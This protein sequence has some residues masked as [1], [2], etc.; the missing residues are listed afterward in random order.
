[1]NLFDYLI[2]QSLKIN[3]NLN[4]FNLFLSFL[5]CAVLP[6]SLFILVCYSTHTLR[7]WLNLDYVVVAVLFCLPWLWVRILAT[8]LLL[9]TFLI[10][11]LLITVQLFPI[12]NISASTHLLPFIWQAPLEYLLML[13]MAVI[14]LIIIFYLSI[15]QNNNYYIKQRIVLGLYVLL[16]GIICNFFITSNFAASQLIF[17]SVQGSSNNYSQADNLNADARMFNSGKKSLSMQLFKNN[18]NNRLLLIIDE[19]W[20]SALNMQLQNAVIQKLLD[21]RNNLEFFEHGIKKFNGVTVQAELKEL[22]QIDLPSLDTQNIVN[23][24]LNNCLPNLLKN[25]GYTTFAVHGSAGSFYNRADW[26]P[27]IGFQHQQFLENMQHLPKCYPFKGVCDSA[28]F[29]DVKKMLLAQPKSFVYW[30]TLTT[31]FSYAEED[32]HNIRLNCAQYDLKLGSKSCRN[33]MLH[34]QFFDQLAQWINDPQMKG[35]E[36]VVIGDHPPP[37]F[38]TVE[39]NT[40]YNEYAVSWLHFKIK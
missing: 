6:N 17:F 22:C 3:I 27:A 29:A 9:Y 28:I 37:M 19:S 4:I 30:M 10:D 16:T 18:H 1:M 23:L 35:V 40:V 5:I 12:Q 31:H 21:K 13:G 11:C 8:A 38:D 2:G 24:N 20:G 33:N 39:Q 25:R 36:V 34:A 32:I 15:R 14:W 7:P 26:Y